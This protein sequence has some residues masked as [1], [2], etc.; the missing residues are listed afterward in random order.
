MMISVIPSFKAT[1]PGILS[2]WTFRDYL[3]YII[4]QKHFD[5]TAIMTS[6]FCTKK[7]LLQKFT[8]IAG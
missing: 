6:P 8:K 1:K 3:S 2:F 4:S 7:N 5:Y